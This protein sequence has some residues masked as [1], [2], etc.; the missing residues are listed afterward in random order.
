MPGQYLSPATRQQCRQLAKDGQS[1]RHIAKQLHISRSSAQRHAH[2]TGPATDKPKSGR[3]SKLTTNQRR[4]VRRSALAGHSTVSIA[5]R[6]LCRHGVDVHRTTV[7]RVLKSGRKP[8]E[9]LPVMKGRGLHPSNM[10]KRVAFC[11]KEQER[12]WDNVVFIDSKYLYVYRDQ[13]KRWLFR[14]QDPKSKE[15][16]PQNSNPFVFHFYAAVGKGL[17]TLLVF[18]PPTRGEGV[19]DPR[20]KT[21][22]KSK[23]FVEALE[24]LQHEIV[25]GLRP[26]ARYWV[27]M[28]NAKQHT[29]R[30]SVAAIARLGVPVLEGFPAQSW[31]L[32]VIEVCWAWLEQNLRGHNPRTWDGWKR[33][34]IQAWREVQQTSIN[35]L[36]KRV[37][38][39]VSKIQEAGG[40]WCKYFP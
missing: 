40:K 35:K 25:R 5:N 37:P 4:V 26:G 13:A 20:G 24:Q 1:I 11:V 22:F 14:W 38:K 3:P 8:L 33:A 28:D 10:Q 2:A 15:V 36:V 16:V 27:V 7:G 29:S 31:D 9:Y 21:S 23:H 18:V 32:N 34:I 30:E 17:K 19:D 12:K 39:Q 6:L